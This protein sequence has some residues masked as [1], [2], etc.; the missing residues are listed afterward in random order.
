MRFAETS[1]A[2][3]HFNGLIL[4]KNP[5]KGPQTRDKERYQVTRAYTDIF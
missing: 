5:R 4:K 3:G 2:D 1:I